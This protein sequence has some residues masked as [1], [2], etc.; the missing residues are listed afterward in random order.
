MQTKTFSPIYSIADTF[1]KV[2]HQEMQNSNIDFLTFGTFLQGD[3]P[4]GITY[5]S[6][7]GAFGAPTF[8][9]YGQ[10]GKI[11]AEWVILTPCGIVT[12]YNWKNGQNWNGQEGTPTQEIANWNVGGHSREA[13]IY[14]AEYL[15]KQKQAD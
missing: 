11:D 3:L 4:L 14:L 2:A 7:V 6:I 10:G 13:Y 8:N 5:Q 12:I 9:F 15:Q 1:G